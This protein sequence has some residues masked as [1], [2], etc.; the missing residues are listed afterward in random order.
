MA[1]ILSS[2]R[3]AVSWRIA[4]IVETLPARGA[5]TVTPRYV[6]NQILPSGPSSISCTGSLHIGASA[7]GNSS[8]G[9][10]LSFKG[11]KTAAPPYVAS[12]ISPFDA[13]QSATTAFLPE[14]GESGAVRGK[15]LNVP[16]SLS[17]RL[18][19]PPQVPTQMAPEASSISAITLLFA[20]LCG[21]EGSCP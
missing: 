11:S 14:Y 19:P 3:P 5:N 2:H 9:T 6:P 7:G 20:R 17:N 18:N 4:R 15:C 13:L 1:R 16:A 12:Q 10:Y 21:C 8:C